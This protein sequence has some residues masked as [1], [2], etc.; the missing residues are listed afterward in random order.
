MVTLDCKIAQLVGPQYY[1]G[2]EQTAETFSCLLPREYHQPQPDSSVS[3]RHLDLDLGDALIG[4]SHTDEDFDF[5]QLFDL[6]PEELFNDLPSNSPLERK[7]KAASEEESAD[8]KK[9]RQ[10]FSNSD[11]Y[12]SLLSFH[13]N[14]AALGSTHLH[15][16][17]PSSGQ[18]TGSSDSC[19][20]D[21]GSP[22]SPE[23]HD[24]S[25][26]SSCSNASEEL[27]DGQSV[28]YHF[29]KIQEHVKAAVD[30]L[31]HGRYERNK[32]IVTWAHE[33]KNRTFSEV[34]PLVLYRH[35]EFGETAESICD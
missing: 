35:A 33:L 15:T 12:N 4:F 1:P 29:K 23:I 8:W 3:N 2:E 26:V 21:P 7:R 6:R 20:N 13:E 27:V 24:T 16:G 11:S 14:N 17:L 22:I 5:S 25:P 30:A 10:Q 9:S 31:R 28:E 34:S 32:N 19:Y 18:D